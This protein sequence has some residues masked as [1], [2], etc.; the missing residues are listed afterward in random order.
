MSFWIMGII[1]LL[2]ANVPEPLLSVAHTETTVTLRTNLPPLDFLH[3]V[4]EPIDPASRPLL[5]HDTTA[6]ARPRTR[7]NSPTV[8]YKT[9][10]KLNPAIDAEIVHICVHQ[11]RLTQQK[12]ILGPDKLDHSID[13]FTL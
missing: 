3:A 12:T 5:R 8:H 2:Q 13:T 1:F 9:K 11:R 4:H 6:R 10:N 7:C